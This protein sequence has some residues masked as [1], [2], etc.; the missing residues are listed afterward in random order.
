MVEQY[1]LDTNPVID[2]FNGSV[3][4]A[5]KNFIAR[6]EPA[7]SIISYIEMFSNKNVPKLEWNQL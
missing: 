3:P 7:I 5:G 1:L 6:I 2:F 4:I